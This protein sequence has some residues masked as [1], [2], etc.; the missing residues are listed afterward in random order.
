MALLLLF[1]SRAAT[2]QSFPADGDWVPLPCGNGVMVDPAGDTPNAIGALDVVGTP[3]AP[4]GHHAADAQFLYLRLRVA[5]DPRQ[6]ARLQPNAWGFELDTDGNRST[7]ELLLSVSGTGASDQVAVFRHASTSGNDSPAD[8]ATLPPAFIY[9]AATHARVAAANT[10]LGGGNDFFVELAVPFSDLATVGVQRSTPVYAWAGS[11]TV[12]NA[13]DL[14]LACS[15]GA[16]AGLRL[17]AIDSGRVPIDPTAP[18]GGPDG[19]TG[20]PGG[21]GPRTLEGGPGCAVTG[22]ATAEGPWPALMAL[23]VLALQRATSSRRPISAAG[24]RTSAAGPTP[25]APAGPARAATTAI[26]APPATCAART[27]PAAAARS[28][29]PPRPIRGPASQRREA[30]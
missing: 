30:A 14:D 13:L 8:P 10:T 7:Y 25:P 17:G 21:P 22:S 15:S 19:G 1:A 5:G 18:S 2:A 26:P 6:G 24:R 23:L 11:S 29:A 3:G 27:A 28:P 20:G 4:A 16:G 12:S 9:P